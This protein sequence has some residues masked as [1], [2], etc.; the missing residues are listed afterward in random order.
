MY[1]EY[2]VKAVESIIMYTFQNKKLLEQALTH[3]TYAD[4]RS[5]QRLEF[6]GD[7]ALELAISSFFYLTYPDIDA[8]KLSD[9][10]AANVSNERLA[11][12][13]VHHGVHKYIRHSKFES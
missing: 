11:R 4:G 6:L 1:M 7:S 3:P 10:R 2:S 8:G 5:Y 13:A 12:V 9:L